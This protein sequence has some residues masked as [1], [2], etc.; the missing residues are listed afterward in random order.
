MRSG[1]KGKEER[2]EGKG[3]EGDTGREGRD[4]APPMFDTDRR[5]WLCVLFTV[6]SCKTS[7]VIS[8]CRTKRTARLNRHSLYTLHIF[9]L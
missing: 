8:T 7:L 3:E 5:P 2:E 1:D 6:I 4:W 9:V